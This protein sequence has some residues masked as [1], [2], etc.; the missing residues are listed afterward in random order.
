VAFLVVAFGAMAS[1][2]AEAAF[3]AYICNDASC[4]GGD[5]IAVTDNNGASLNGGV[6]SIPLL[7]FISLNAVNFSGFTITVNQ[8]Q[9]KP[10]LGL[11]MDLNYSVTAG[12][13][14]GGTVWL[15]ASDTDFS[16]SVPGFSGV[17]G[18]TSD[19]GSVT[20]RICGGNSNSLLD[21]TSCV[22]ATDNTTPLISIALGK[23]GPTVNPY[24]L[25]L[26]VRVDLTGPNTTATGDF[27]VVPVPEPAS[28]SLFG[29]GLAGM[30]ALRRRRAA[31]SAQ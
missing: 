14:A 28:L 24:S 16:P 22:S 13:S 17:L 31:R 27:R 8:S 7:G 29:L 12:P 23:D 10:L 11:G 9:S 6:D 4:L 3:A 5:D 1:S 26:G 30:A 21:L 15:Y 25:T 20:A 18:G 2:K 19:N